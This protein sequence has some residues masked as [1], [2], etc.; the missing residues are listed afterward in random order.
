MVPFA[1]TKETKFMKTGF[2]YKITNPN[3]HIYI[4]QTDNLERRKYVYKKYFAKGQHKLHASFLN[5]GFDSHKIETLGEYPLC[6]IDNA[7]I[8]FINKYKSQD[9]GLNI[10]KGG[11]GVRGFKWSKKSIEKT[12]QKF[13]KYSLDGELLKIYN[14][15]K[16]AIKEEGISIRK[17]SNKNLT[18]NGF[19]W[20]VEGQKLPDFNLIKTKLRISE[21][22]KTII[23]IDMKGK[24]VAEFFGAREASRQ[25]NIDHRSISHVASGRK[26]RKT[27][28][29]FYW[30][31]KKSAL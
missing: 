30:K 31:Y 2:I 6:F 7:E 21:K 10:S 20:I 4:G 5:H 12:F 29:G 1:C 13:Y 27:A 19:I 23:Q 9:E 22:C 14:S 26:S 15:K 11:K 17:F 18:I 16:Q 28:G 24:I 8:F 25:T 3:N